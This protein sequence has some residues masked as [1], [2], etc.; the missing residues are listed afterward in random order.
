MGIE[1]MSQFETPDARRE[2]MKTQYGE[3]LTQVVLSNEELATR[4]TKNLFSEKN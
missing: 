4:V 3:N 2:R 1:T